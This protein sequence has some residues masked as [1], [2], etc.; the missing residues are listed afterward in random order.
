MF[1]AWGWTSIY[2]FFLP[3][4]SIFFLKKRFSLW[5]YS[6]CPFLFLTTYF[7]SFTHPPTLLT[8]SILVKKTVLF[9][10]YYY[11][12][13]EVSSFQFMFFVC[14]YDCRQNIGRDDYFMHCVNGFNRFR[15]FVSHKMTDIDYE[16]EQFLS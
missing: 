11:Y 7:L 5:T 14:H 8:V 13:V 2:L 1:C 10:F 16:Y 9:F 4:S 6:F 15:F 3:L 12:C